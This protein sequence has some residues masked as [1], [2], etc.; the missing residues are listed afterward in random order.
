MPT[1]PPGSGGG[2][3]GPSCTHIY[4][5]SELGY[6]V[7]DHVAQGRTVHTGLAVITGTEDRQHAYV[8]LT[9][10]TDANLAYVFTVSP[11]RADPVPGPRPAPE[12]AR[13]DQIHAERRGVRAPVTR[14][15][16]PGT[17]LGVL[18]AVLDR[19]GQQLSAT[20][21]RQQALADADH[22]ALLHAIWTAET[23]PAREQ[24]YRDL[25][26]A[27]LPPG[28][29]RASPATRP[30]GCGAPCAAPNWP[31]WTPGRSWPRRSASG[32]WPA[33]ATCPASSTPGSG[34]GSAAWSRFRPAR[35]PRRSPP[36]PTPN[37]APTPR[38]SPR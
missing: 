10:G 33:P 17:A 38:R 13:Y 8:A 7:T 20:Q 18:A 27:A 26:L 14:P 11:K 4:G 2:P 36:S 31:A 22:L 16:P 5:D 15:A 1:R 6:A 34:T 9:R 19:D 12:L 21:T 30:D 23:A 3:T 28:L 25:L 24:R 35:G 37:A 29:P 32:T